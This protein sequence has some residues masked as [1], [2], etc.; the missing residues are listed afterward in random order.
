MQRIAAGEGT[1]DVDLSAYVAAAPLTPM[2][3]DAEPEETY[4]VGF[5]DIA[6][7][8]LYEV[9][10]D[11]KTVH[12]VQSCSDWP[13][14]K[15]AMDHEMEAL[16]HAGTW[17]IVKWVLN[18]N[19]VSCKWVFKLK[20]Q[21]DGSIDK[22]KARLVAQGFTQIPGVDYHETYSPVACLS[23]FRLTL[24]FAA[25]HD[26]EIEAFDFNLAFL[27]GELGDG[28]EIYMKEPPG[29]ESSDGGSVKRLQKGLFMGS[30]RL[31]ESGTIPS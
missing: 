22:Y 16:E 1:I 15:E 12:Q 7:S 10:G 4:I 20:Q 9:K 27:N 28:E 13:C 24:A 6:L 8:V 31:A 11:L 26:W 23:S 25:S 5:E 14:W 21:A 17:T 2:S 19:V 18:T 3:A 30:N 29:F